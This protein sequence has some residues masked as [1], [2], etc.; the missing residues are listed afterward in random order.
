MFISS[1]LHHNNPSIM[2]ED[3]KL[4]P[5]YRNIHHIFWATNFSFFFFSFYFGLFLITV[6][7]MPV[8]TKPTRQLMETLQVLQSKSE[9]VTLKQSNRERRCRWRPLEWSRVTAPQ[10][11][12]ASSSYQC[13]YTGW[14][15][16]DCLALTHRDVTY[17]FILKMEG[18]WLG[19]AVCR[20]LQGC[21]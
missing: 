10:H 1:Q 8:T 21:V 4:Y 19:S 18:Q 12:L 15:G 11:S 7:F 9:R 17:Y 16:K 13:R 6:F 14:C 2:I 5:I 3:I 20:G